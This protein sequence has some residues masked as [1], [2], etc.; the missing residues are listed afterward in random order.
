[1]DC[2]INNYPTI[3]II[4]TA[5]FTIKSHPNPKPHTCVHL[6]QHAHQCYLLLFQNT[7]HALS[8]CP[9]TGTATYYYKQHLLSYSTLREA[10]YVMLVFL[11]FAL[12]PLLCIT[13]SEAI[14]YCVQLCSAN[15]N[16]VTHSTL[17]SP[18][19]TY[20]FPSAHYQNL[21][22]QLTIHCQVNFYF[23][24]CYIVGVLVC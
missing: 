8:S 24:F 5:T 4:H 12:I 23:E 13:T 1:V 10:H 20:Y 22:S 3:I 19:C 15:S 2:Q 7:T 14:Y 16:L 11:L 21:I 9:A 17:H 6:H 18:C